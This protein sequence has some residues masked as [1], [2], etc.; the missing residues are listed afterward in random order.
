MTSFIISNTTI[1]PFKFYWNFFKCIIT[2]FEVVVFS[3]V[4]QP[5]V[6]I[7][8]PIIVVVCIA[9]HLIGIY[10]PS[11]WEHRSEY[12]CVRERTKTRECP[13]TTVHVSVCFAFF[14]YFVGRVFSALS[15]E[16]LW[17]S[18]V[19]RA[20]RYIG[21]WADGRTVGWSVC[22]VVLKKK[23]QQSLLLN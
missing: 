15:F 4:M 3:S 18:V 7:V 22:L 6:S 12:V 2:I 9:L 10:C 13:I 19:C 8:A 14:S 21:W 5:V 11:S 16:F 1:S 20:G 17:L 23:C